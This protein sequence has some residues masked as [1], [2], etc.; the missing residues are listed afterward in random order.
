[1]GS[2]VLFLVLHQHAFNIKLKIIFQENI[3]VYIYSFDM[4]E[5]LF[6]VYIGHLVT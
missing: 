2:W 1:M 4:L 6:S 3:Y 5:T